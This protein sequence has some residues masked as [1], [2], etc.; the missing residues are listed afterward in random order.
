MS[1]EDAAV[2]IWSQSDALSMSK[3]RFFFF[4]YISV[5]LLECAFPCVRDNWFSRWPVGFPKYGHKFGITKNWK[6]IHQRGRKFQMQEQHKAIYIWDNRLVSENNILYYCFV[7]FYVERRC[8]HPNI[9]PIRYFIEQDAHLFLASS[10]LNDYFHPCAII[11]FLANRLVFQNMV[12]YIEFL[13]SAN[14]YC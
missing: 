2:Q 7:T 13:Y 5:F 12:T 4:V 10:C 11:Y 1:R 6:R 8:C 3:M 14:F 9:K